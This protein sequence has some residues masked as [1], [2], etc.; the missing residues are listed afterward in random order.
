MIDIPNDEVTRRMAGRRTDPATGLEYHLED[1]P[2]YP[3]HAI[4]TAQGELT[5]TF[6]STSAFRKQQQVIF[7]R[8]Q[9]VD[10]LESAIGTLTDRLHITD[11]NQAEIAEFAAN[12]GSSNPDTPRLVTIPDGTP[13]RIYDLMDELV[14]DC[15]Q[16]WERQEAEVYLPDVPGGRDEVPPLDFNPL[17]RT[18]GAAGGAGGGSAAGGSGGGGSAAPEE[19]P[20]EPVEPPR[21]LELD[22]LK[23]I[24]SNLE[25]RSSVMLSEMW[26]QLEGK[27]RHEVTEVLHWMKNARTAWLSGQGEMQYRMLAHLRV[28]GTQQD[29]VDQFLD[30]VNRFSDEYP[31]MRPHDATKAELHARTANLAHL[32]EEQVQEREKSAKELRETMIASEWAEGHEMMLAI[33][34]QRLVQVELLCLAGKKAILL[35]FYTVAAGMLPGPTPEMPPRIDVL[36]GEIEVPEAAAAAP[37]KGKGKPT[38]EEEAAAAE[39]AKKKAAQARKPR[40]LTDTEVDEEGNV[41]EESKV[42][43]PMLNLLFD[44]AKEKGREA[45]KSMPWPPGAP[46]EEE[47]V[48]EDKG[49]KAPPKG[50]GKVEE[51][52]EEKKPVKPMPHAW[53]DLHAAIHALKVEF[54]FRMV[55]LRRWAEHALDA[56]A[57]DATILWGSLEKM[58]LLESRAEREAIDAFANEV[59]GYVERAEKF[60]D[61]M[62]LHGNK[63]R[64]H[65]N[66]LL[67]EPPTAVEGATHETVVEGRASLATLYAAL[68]VISAVSRGGVLR[69]RNLNEMRPALWPAGLEKSRDGPTADRGAIAASPPRGEL[70]AVEVLMSLGLLEGS[71][72]PAVAELQACVRT[73][74]QPLHVADAEMTEA[75]F[76]QLP[77]FTSRTDP[78]GFDLPVA[79]RAWVYRVFASFAVGGMTDPATVSVRRVLGF[80]AL[81]PTVKESLSVYADL[82]GLGAS[83]PITVKNLAGFLR[84][85][86]LRPM[87]GSA[88]TPED[89]VAWFRD[90]ITPPPPGDPGIV[91]VPPRDSPPVYEVDLV[92]GTLEG[93]IKSVVEHPMLDRLPLDLGWTRPKFF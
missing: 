16:R 26:I 1:N 78:S 32:L 62:S 39:A 20:E 3:L 28:P 56:M 4:P 66:I 76:V 72:W 19:L 40:V 25:D 30:D 53:A 9:P 74:P 2:P 12:L 46:A 11:V 60:P 45:T 35:D 67:D 64:K 88:I 42:I 5:A 92:Q 86:G 77:L 15:L 65:P 55:T 75:Q 27:V 84:Q 82:V 52:E 24:L 58:V 89:I 8:L 23:D 70:L 87:Q 63:M 29:A 80:L 17:E 83:T 85:D 91:T 59:A 38:P 68:S 37:A 31:A 57:E 93:G 54:E 21:L 7:E 43:Y 73:L 41:V 47:E 34:V 51:E 33:L 36:E 48:V 18:G 13:D 50:K 10:P 6:S 61:L 22:E 79:F 90:L 44:A 71:D 14:A 49:K 69:E 81:Q